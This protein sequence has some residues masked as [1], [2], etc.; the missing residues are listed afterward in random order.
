LERGVERGAEI[1]GYEKRSRWDHPD[2]LTIKS[3]L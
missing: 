2:L 1:G 3:M